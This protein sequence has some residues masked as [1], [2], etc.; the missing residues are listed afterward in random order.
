MKT[1]FKNKGKL[2]IFSGK[3]KMKEVVISKPVLQ[4]IIKEVLKAEE[5]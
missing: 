1:L 5:G 3:A 2:K 4:E